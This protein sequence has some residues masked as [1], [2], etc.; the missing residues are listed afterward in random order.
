MLTKFSA[1]TWVLMGFGISLLAVVINV[2]V[3][4]SINDRI[5]AADGE[6]AKLNTS[7]VNQ[8]TELTRTDMKGDLFLLLHHLSKLSSDK[9]E[10]AL[11]GDDAI[12]MLQEYLKKYYAAANDVPVNEML[13]ATNEELNGQLKEGEK[14]KAAYAILEKEGRT[15]EADRLLQEANEI[16]RQNA[17][18]R[19]DLGKKLDAAAKIP[20]E[21]NFSSK[22]TFEVLLEILPSLKSSN[23]QYIA[24]TQI[25]EAR[26]KELQE[27]KGRLAGWQSLFSFL[28]VSLQLFGLM[29]VL[30]K[31]LVKDT[32]ERRDKAEKRARVIEETAIRN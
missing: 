28:A 15:P 2:F 20:D 6:I 16:T 9:D 31:D 8:A 22:K 30:T 19:S 25:K 21:E 17:Q 3:L 7:L 27:K 32:K 12:L 23:E 10:Q 24:S 1:R 26:I 18:A 29:F 13:K 14:A 11:A 4:S 5:K